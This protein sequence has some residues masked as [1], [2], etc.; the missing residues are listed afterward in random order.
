MDHLK[1]VFKWLDDQSQ[2]VKSKKYA[3]FL[4][5]GEFLRH[6]LTKDGI[7]IADVKVS[8]V[9]NWLLIKTVRYA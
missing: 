2:Y 5:K 8:E 1:W 6:V 4:N 9:C 7:S 3:P